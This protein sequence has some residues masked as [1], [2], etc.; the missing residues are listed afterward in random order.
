MD[1]AIITTYCLADDWLRARR[2][3]ESPQRTVSDAEVMST[4]IVAARF[5]GGNFETASGLLC[6]DEYFGHRLS[7]SRFNLRLHLLAA[8]LESFFEWIGQVHKAASYESVFLIDSCP[9]KVCDNIRIDRCRVYPK[10]ATKDA[11]RGYNS[12]K[13]RFFYG[14]KIHALM[15]ADGI[16]VEVSLTPGS[17]SDTTMPIKG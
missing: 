3:Q 8:L 7:R 1:T 17:Y 13:R 4:A 10:T 12:S 2:H 11:F 6:K 9:V 5:F 14:L 16:P 15:T